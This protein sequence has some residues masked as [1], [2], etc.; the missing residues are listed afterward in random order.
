MWKEYFDKVREPGQEINPVLK[1]LGIGIEEISNDK[2]VLSATVRPEFLH[3]GGFAAG[4]II[5]TLADEA[6]GHLSAYVMEE[7]KG[8]A[9][10]EMNIRYLKTVKSGKIKAEARIVK[11]GRK[12]ITVQ[13]EVKDENNVILATAGASFIAFDIKSFFQRNKGE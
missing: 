5:G 7:E 11:M 3:A 8:T 1:F 10:I 4:G 2:A 9:T 12:V 13:A 6:M